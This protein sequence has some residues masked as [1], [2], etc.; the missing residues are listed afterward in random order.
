MPARRQ[1][2]PT[3]R[4]RRLAAELRR[5]RGQ[6]GLTREE[7]TDRTGINAATLY[8]IEMVQAR[9]QRRTLMALLELYSV[10]DDDRAGL[11]ELLRQAGEPSWIQTFP[12]S[13]PEAYTTFFLF[14]SEATTVLN[15][16]ALF[17]P[18]L[19]QT[20][21]YARGI[22]RGTVPTATRD[23]IR[24][25]VEARMSRQAVL[26]R[27]VP[28]RLWAIVDEAAL[29]RPVGGH[30]VMAAQLDHLAE[31]ATEL[32]HVTLQVIPYDV[33]AHPGMTASF[34]VLQFGGDPPTGDVVYHESQTGD[35]FLENE[36]DVARF[37]AIFEHLRAMALAPE[38][39]TALLRR[40]ARD[41]RGGAEA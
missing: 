37:T 5:L 34:A 16:E 8:R 18:G 28:L 21:D 19:L 31:S 3:L 30:Q 12:S 38:Q 33:G 35:L 40:I 39:S 29:H 20:E 36:T 11:L 7:V 17:V 27:D 25:L 26:T 14:E 2:A 32:P 22:Y 1:P 41:M 24:N 9:P 15:Y 10:P 4:L 6:V 13:L 23:E